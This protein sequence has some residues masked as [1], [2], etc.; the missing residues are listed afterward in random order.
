[1]QL[2]PGEGHGGRAVVMEHNGNYCRDGRPAR[3]KRWADGDLR[4]MTAG[5]H[6]RA[7]TDILAWEV[8]A[9]PGRRNVPP[10]PVQPLRGTH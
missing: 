9:G 3:W 8:A 10:V 2:R 5:G 1:M 6:A 4:T 7:G